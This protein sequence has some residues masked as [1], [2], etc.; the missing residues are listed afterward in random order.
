MHSTDWKKGQNIRYFLQISLV[1]PL[2]SRITEH[3][4]DTYAKLKIF[5]VA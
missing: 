3:N 5:P 2:N 1:W 4:C